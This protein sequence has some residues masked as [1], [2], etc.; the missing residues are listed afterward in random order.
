MPDSS[1][2]TN[3]MRGLAELLDKINEKVREKR[4]RDNQIGHSWETVQH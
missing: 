4:S 2:L 1:I 3:G